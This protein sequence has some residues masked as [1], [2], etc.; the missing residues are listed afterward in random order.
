MKVVNKAF[1]AVLAMI[2]S[3]SFFAACAKPG[4][5]ES[6]GEDNSTKTQLTIGV[7][8]GGLGWTWASALADKF[9]E[10]YADV[11]FEEGKVGVEVQITPGEKTAYEPDPLITNIQSGNYTQD[12]FYTAASNHWDFYEKGVAADIDDILTEKVYDESGNL[13]DEGQGTMSIAD[14]MDPYFQTGFKEADGKYH[15]FPYM[16]SI[17]GIVYDHDLLTKRGILHEDADGNVTDYPKTYTEFKEMLDEIQTAGMIGL[18]YSAQDASFYTTCIYSALVAQNE[19]LDAAQLNLSYGG[20][21]GTDYIFPAGTF[22]SQELAE[23]GGTENA[24]G[25]T[26]KI[27]AA[28]AY[29]LSHQ[30]GK[31]DA[32][33]FVEML[34]GNG[35]QYLD[36]TVSF[37]TQ[38][39]SETQKSFINSEKLSQEQPDKAQPIAMIVE[40][41]W[42]ENE[43]RQH[44]IDMGTAFGDAVYGYGKRDFR[45]MPLPFSDNAKS[46]TEVYHSLSSG[47]IAF[48]NR[49]SAHKDLAGLW[50]QFSLQ[51]SSLEE[52]TLETGAVLAYEYD[53]SEEQKS[54]LT[55]FA[56]NVYEI[57]KERDNV[58][59][60]RHT[61]SCDFKR[62]GDAAIVGGYGDNMTCAM[63][64]GNV[65]SDPFELFLHNSNHYTAQD[66]I[67]GN[68][69]YLNK[70]MWTQKYSTYLEELS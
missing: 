7:Y 70:E 9:E 5:T 32:M 56:R 16:D 43:A 37:A 4:Q 6:G 27:T 18:T 2:F 52:F 12:I 40:G 38:S 33:K 25:Q 8:N 48:V 21:E 3:V 50:I 26:V 66:Y 68:I 47:S 42:W 45:F 10:A 23:I 49:N 67:N 20:N 13:A 11:S 54:Q 62:Y 15:G 24:A 36:P 55:P 30:P 46:D 61:N 28:N 1:G 29:L 17:V 57:R 31:L 64:S 65:T 14:K 41:E 35:M 22:T 19:G 58:V 69:A 51:E 60:S 44:F 53:L 34:F 39:Y 63:S 59:I